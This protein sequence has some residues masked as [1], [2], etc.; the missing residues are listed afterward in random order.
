[1]SVPFSKLSKLTF[2]S[3][4]N[5]D[6]ELDS[7][8]K[9]TN[10]DSMKGQIPAV[11]GIYDPHMGSTNSNQ[12]CESCGYYKIKCPGHPGS[13]YLNYPCLSP[14][15]IKEI[16]KWLKVICFNCAEPIESNIPQV[17][18]AHILSNFVK[19]CNKTNKINYCQNCKQPHPHITM[20]KKDKTNI[21]IE[22]EKKNKKIIYAKEISNIL[23][24]IT[25]ETVLKLGKPLVSHPRNFIITVLR[26][27]PNTIRPDVRKIG[28]KNNNNDVTI[29]LKN[30]ITLNME[31]P[32]QIDYIDN[33]LGQKIQALNNAV[34]DMIKGDSSKKLNNNKPLV[35]IGKRWAGKMGRI[36]RHL[37][38]RR[39]NNMGR[40]FITCDTFLKTNQVGIPVSIAK[41]I[42]FGE[43]VQSYNYD[44]MMTYFLNGTL[45]YPGCKNIVKA[46]DGNTYNVDKVE[47]LEIG[48]V[49]YRNIVTG[50]KVQFNRQPS[51]ESSSLSCMDIVVMDIGYTFR[52]NLLACN[53]FNAD[54]DGDAMNLMFPRSV[55]V[56]N[57]ISNLSSPY[58]F[59]ISHRNG[60]PAVG[61][62]Q[63]S[64]I[65][66]A[67]LTYDSTNLDKLHIMNLFSQVNT[68]PDFSKNNGIYKG[69]D[70]INLY[71]KESE[72]YINYSGSA[73]YYKE[74]H[75]A[76]RSYNSKDIQVVIDKGEIKSGVL[77]KNAIGQDSQGS[78]FHIIHNQ[79][80]SH[81]ALDASYYIQ[82][83]ALYYS[84]NRGVTVS[85]KDLLVNNQALKEI[86]NIEN[87]I[88][89]EAIEINNRLNK[90]NII[91]PLGKTT[92]EYFE[93]MVINA[94]EP[95]DAYWPYILKS[96]DA[97]TNMLYLMIT[98]GSRGKL[99]NFSQITSAIGQQEINGERIVENFG[100]RTLC[101][102]TKNDP[103]PIARGY[104]AN[105]YIS[106]I[107][108]AEFYFGAEVARY[109][110]I[111]KALSTSIAGTY[112]RMA[113]KNMESL[114]IDVFRRVS[115]TGKIIQFLYGSDGCDSRFIEKVKFP[116]MKK[117]LNLEKFK[118]IY[119]M[120]I[121]MFNKDFHNSNVQ[122]LL[123]QEYE[124][125]LNDRKTYVNI[126][127]Q[128]E[129][130]NKIYS[131]TAILPCNV[132]RI[133]ENVIFNLK[134]NETKSETDLD[135]VKTIES[136][137]KLCNILAQ[138]LM[139]ED[140]TELP[141]YIKNST[142]LLCM[143]I[144]SY[145]NT[146]NLIKNK[147]TNKALE[148][149]IDDI[150]NIYSKSLICYGK[151]CG[152]I[153]SQS[154]SQPL[155]QD[156]LNS[157]HSAGISSTKKKGMFRIK[158]ILGV[159][160]TEN[161]ES[162][163]MILNV[164]EEFRNNKIKVQEIAN[165]IEMLKFSTF[166][167]DW[168][169][170]YEKYGNPVHS[171]YKHEKEM[172][173]EFEKYNNV[174]VPSDLLDW[175]FR[176]VF[177]K[178]KLIEKQLKLETVYYKLRKEFPYCFIVYNNEN[179]D[180]VIMRIYFRTNQFNKIPTIK[181]LET[182][183]DEMLDTVIRGVKGV[184]NASVSSGPV[185]IQKPDGSLE[186][187]TNYFIVTEG[188]NLKEILTNP[189]IDADTVQ[190]DSIVEMCELFG[191]AAA[192]QKIITELKHQIDGSSHRHY[193]I[194]ADTMTRIGLLTGIDRYGSAKRETSIMQRI[195]DS[196]PIS[197]L[198][199]AS[200]N[201]LS[202]KLTNVSAN[203]MMGQNPEIGDLYS[204]FIIDS[205][206]VDSNTKN[207]NDL[208]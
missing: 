7:T 64:I 176:F 132:S 202:D 46:S 44:R 161:M 138:C 141:D 192:R 134:L 120:N 121:K 185:T 43:T 207:L 101:Y 20:E 63:D 55:R 80:G 95:G 116:T 125:L 1:M 84:F 149:I 182:L 102:F 154:I 61:E 108:P 33:E 172:I 136:V 177:N 100:G 69:R 193:T 190:S 11:D 199:E 41:E 59:F 67:L 178:F 8:V 183:K 133:M 187:T 113:I 83:I 32:E 18:K 174:Q 52:M 77:D 75:S 114:I 76:Y 109:S 92:E 157:H 30:I 119:H 9:V 191:I 19:Q 47:K 17:K 42:S 34:Y 51:L 208:I 115:D 60:K 10:S 29:L 204:S 158:E 129:H 150:K 16:S 205:E 167:K 196:N 62:A 151:M 91:P 164:V 25:D 166:I 195:S 71:L 74:E 181:N 97:E 37:L 70:V 85:I 86:H 72:F 48:D 163:S 147:I 143:H 104:I 98:H 39:T 87:A 135:P 88:I 90:G 123:D 31:I 188:T 96:I 201:G 22:D 89:Q 165:H 35:S 126:F 122:K 68:Y 5:Y 28:G 155:T 173:K 107:N 139:N 156:V 203:I 2:Y 198:E 145:L 184:I 175:C 105:S 206:F 137:N 73:S 169:I 103:D 112:N 4:G 81:A 127:L 162:P 110:L 15:Y 94:L 93:Q 79:Y 24:R 38:G 197:V 27:P 14:M 124:T 153:A 57:E 82:Q 12:R 170:F 13:Y 58:Q 117:D 152:I 53:F 160:P 26:V 118:E 200:I 49:I 45:R 168:K 186:S 6:N 130:L 40:S 179:S 106:G 36:R 146:S 99:P 50:D 54:F 131:D 111:N 128:M 194:Y 144:R 140:Q 171:K 148:I 159:K 78:I 180:E 23:N 56:V 142:L 3:L 189:Y 66:T 65:L 21:Y